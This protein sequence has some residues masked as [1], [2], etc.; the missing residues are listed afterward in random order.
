MR[1]KRILSGTFS[2]PVYHITSRTCNADF[3]F[4]EA[5]K[6]KLAGLIRGYAGFC[7]VEIFTWCILSNHFHIL[8]EVP[9][10]QAEQIDDP[11]LLRRLACIYPEPVVRKTR[12]AL[13]HAAALGGESGRAVRERVRAPH[14]KRMG[15]LADFLKGIKQSFTQWFNKRR[16]REGTAWQGRFHSSL[17]GGEGEAGTAS[18]ARVVAAYIDLNPVRAGLVGD[19][20]DYA[21]SGYGAAVGGGDAQA[22]A[23][24]GRL[25]GRHAKG[26]GPAGAEELDGYRLLLLETG[27]EAGQEPG[28]GRAGVAAGLVAQARRERRAG[29]P[30]HRRI[31]PMSR[32]AVV[33]D[34]AFVAQVDKRGLLAGRLGYLAAFTIRWERAVGASGSNGLADEL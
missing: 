12:L 14:L 11:E 16:E 31:E 33:G 34:A 22:L 18:V 15:S 20:K 5:C 17:V 3:Y 30:L 23:G 7:G 2:R 21:W 13:E 10:C 1:H 28:G 27:N 4:D 6:R 32:A 8:C 29:L 19:P 25:L 24:L 9:P 26:A